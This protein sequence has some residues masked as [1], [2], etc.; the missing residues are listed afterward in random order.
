VPSPSSGQVLCTT[1]EVVADL[2]EVVVRTTAGR[3]LLGPLSLTL[4]AGEHWAVLGPN[5][6][7]KTTMLRL[8]AAERHPT[9]GTVTVLGK[10][11]GRAD[12]RALRSEVGVVSHLIADR[13]PVGASAAELVMTGKAGHLAPW[14]D[15]FGPADRER[16]AEL[17]DDLGCGEIA[18]QPF[19][20]CSQ[21]ERQRILIARSLFVEHNLLLLDEPCAG[22]DLPGREAF[23]AALD[24]IAAQ[25]GA[26]VTVHVSHSLEELPT[27]TTHALALRAGGLV[28]AGPVENVLTDEILSACFAL[29]MV[30]RRDDG[31]WAARAAARWA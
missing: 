20:A 22:V 14:W 19:G 31:R 4:H 8:L 6:A 3:V 30:V 16:A 28:A 15:R 17:L 24:R 12:L 7:G 18:A 1:G 29:P 2:H 13:L 21:G 25:P 27:S 11:F 5:G 26:P 10:H 9:N 23:I